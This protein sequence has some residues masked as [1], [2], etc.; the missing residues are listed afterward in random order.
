MSE[1]KKF[2]IKDI[3]KLANVSIATVDRV[4]NNRKDVSDVTREKIQKIIKENNYR[5]NMYARSLS[6]KNN[7]SIAVLIPR[8]SQQTGYWELCL[9]GINKGIDEFSSFG[10]NIDVFLYDQEDVSTFNKAA[11][12]VFETKFNAVVVAPIFIEETRCFVDRCK[13]NGLQT[14]FINS[15]IPNSSSLGYVGP[16]L[17]STGRLAGNLTSYLVQDE[18]KLLILNVG[19]GLQNYKY[20]NTKIEGYTKYLENLGRN[21][22]IVLRDIHHNDYNDVSRELSNLVEEIVPDLIF[23][24]N[25]RVSV[26]G[27]FFHERPDFVKPHIIG[28]D[29]LPSNVDYLA[30]GVVDFLICQRPDKQGYL[31]IEYLYNYFLLKEKPADIKSM[32]IDILTIENYLFYEN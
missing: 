11:D 9:T 15:D 24:T 1:K 31:A 16:D 32:P 18:S 12:T 25:S 8:T 20:L 17:Y 22:D 3:A 7:L 14:I 30:K 6:V 4:L 23:V 28:F 13:Q 2:G 27:Q 19:K 29:F 21:F 26:V 5:P 10:I